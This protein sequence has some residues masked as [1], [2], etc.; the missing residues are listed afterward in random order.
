MCNSVHLDTLT[1]FLK[2]RRFSPLREAL[3]F[4]FF[5][6]FLHVCYVILLHC[7]IKETER[8]QTNKQTN[9][10]KLLRSAKVQT[11]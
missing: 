5:F 10:K 8:K 1:V 7:H 6:F 11:H 2:A 3:P 4:F 9:K